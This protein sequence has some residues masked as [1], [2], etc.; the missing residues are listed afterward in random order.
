M[1]SERQREKAVLYNEM[2][3][4]GGR[5][6]QLLGRF[7]LEHAPSGKE[8]AQT[9]GVD[10]IAVEMTGVP[11][12]D[13]PL[14]MVDLIAGDG[15]IQDFLYSEVGD[16]ALGVSPE[17]A[18]PWERDGKVG[19][20]TMR[21]LDTY[22]ES[23][24]EPVEQVAPLVEDTEH[25]IVGG[26]KIKVDG[27]K[28]ITFEE[29]G[30]LSIAGESK[31]GYRKWGAEKSHA[32]HIAML[33]WDVC[34]SAHSCFRVLVNRGYASCFGIDNPSKS[35]GTV[36]V[37]QW[38]DPGTYRAVHGGKWPNKRCLSSVDFS[39]AVRIKY[40]E[41]YKKMTGID[42]PLIRGS[43]NHGTS[44]LLGMYKNQLVAWLRIERELGKLWD[45]KPWLATGRSKR[46]DFYPACTLAPTSVWDKGDD[47]TIRTHL[48]YTAKKWDI[49]GYQEQLIVLYLTDPAF[50]DEFPWL[51]D[52]FKLE[53]SYWT[54]WLETIKETWTWDEIGL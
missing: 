46:P 50:R 1:L 52:N 38:L 17:P 20:G 31:S 27:V 6:A 3:L 42:R 45:M 48:E 41:R 47:V 4:Y 22:L 53:E 12:F 24:S 15:G 10:P 32:T 16:E 5:G 37:Y 34:F 21:R 33:H 18:T 49:A 54:D 2:G 28:I 8:Y 43:R 14:T 11:L 25:V 40:A 29:P 23:L 51:K 13:D 26:Q 30:G 7:W 36:T 19:P 35:D 39:N 44:S 9:N